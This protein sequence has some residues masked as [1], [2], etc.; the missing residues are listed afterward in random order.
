MEST[1]SYSAPIGY[2]GAESNVNQVAAEDG[3]Y[4]AK[5]VVAGPPEI[6]KTSMLNRYVSPDLD[7]STVYE[8]TVGADFRVA[9]VQVN[10]IRI[11]LQVWDTA[12]DKK[13]LPMSKSL[14]KDADGIILV[15]DITR[16]ATFR[17]LDEYWE[18][19]LNF[20]GVDEMDTFPVILVGNKSDLSDKRQVSLEEVIDWCTNKRPHKQ[21][22]YLECSSK[23]T[24]Y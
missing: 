3:D 22:T 21:I 5:I 8:P 15:Y 7:I 16:R 19:F 23:V 14:Y 12:G 2:L 6:G 10:D 4:V 13:M 1:D 9:E 24:D 17:A 20:S 18:N 11:T